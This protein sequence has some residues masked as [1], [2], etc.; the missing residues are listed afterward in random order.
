MERKAKEEIREHLREW[1]EKLTRQLPSLKEATK[2]VPPDDA[3]GRLT[4][5]DAIQSQEIS[6]N[7]LR[8]VH[9]QLANLEI[10]LKQIDQP[11]FGLCSECFTPIPAGRLKAMPGAMRCV[12]CA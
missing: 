7:A 8:Q 9:T 6:R 3:I 11:D 4:R 1:R 10:A 12:N 2:P 5:L